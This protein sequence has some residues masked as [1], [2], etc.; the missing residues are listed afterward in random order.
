MTSGTVLDVI[1][2]V[3]ILQQNRYVVKSVFQ[4]RIYLPTCE[5]G[6]VQFKNGQIGS[7]LS[8]SNG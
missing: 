4:L 8:N 5:I 1:F 3:D 7:F 6:N 2:D